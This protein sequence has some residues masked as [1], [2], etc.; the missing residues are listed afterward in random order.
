MDSDYILARPSLLDFYKEVP[1]YI[2][3]GDDYIF[4]KPEGQTIGE[5]R[6]HQNRHP[7]Q[8]YLLK[9][10]KIKGLQETQKGFNSKIKKQ[11]KSGNIG[12]VK[13]T[14]MTIMKETLSEPCTGS[15][16]GLSDTVDIL[17]DAYVGQVDVIKNLLNVS[18][19]DY[20]TTLHS[21][22][23][24]AI[25]IGFAAHNGF[26]KY[27]TKIIGL[28]ALLHD[29]GKT[30]IKSKILQAPQK[31]TRN[32]FNEIR[33]HTLFGFN[34]LDKCYF[35]DNRVKLTALGHH[36]RLDGKGYPNYKTNLPSFT[37]ILGIIDCYEA[38][39]N[40]DRPYRN[41]IKPMEALTIIKKEVHNGKFDNQLFE[42]LVCS[43]A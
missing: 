4:Y 37:K 9:K 30:K 41:S 27:D 2:K 34:I 35:S 21:I 26:D 1:L 23:V 15:L 20:S 18:T 40:D 22:N 24:M 19:K 33:R 39:I 17:V 29:V 38:L 25:S 31:L 11:V 36:E 43:L 3:E 42:Q 14:L 28:A 13:E 8:L 6:L 16:E 12:H 32:E 7:Q 5:I 10:D